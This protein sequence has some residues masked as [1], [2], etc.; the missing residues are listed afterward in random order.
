[1]LLTMLDA[2]DRLTEIENVKI[3]AF[4]ESGISNRQVANEIR[5]ATVIDNFVRLTALYGAKKAKRGPEKLSRRQRNQIC[6]KLK[7]TNNM[8]EKLKTNWCF[9]LLFE[10][11][12]RVKQLLHQSS[13]IK[14]RK[15]WKSQ[16]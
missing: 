13:T 6:E 5:S 10:V 2:T 4:K 16:G 3:S 1:M 12:R 11:S 9:L 8:L 14:Y 7:E 15:D